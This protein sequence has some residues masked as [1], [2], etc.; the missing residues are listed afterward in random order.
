[1]LFVVQPGLNPSVG[2]A[3][4]GVPHHPPHCLLRAKTPYLPATASPSPVLL[5]AVGSCYHPAVSDEGAPTD[6][7]APNLEAGLPRPLALR[8]HGPTHNAA[9]GALEATVWGC[10]EKAGMNRGGGAG[11]SSEN[12]TE[13]GG[14]GDP[15]KDTGG[16]KG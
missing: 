11:E 2:T 8:G 15:R 10:G 5:E 4:L 12:R 9:G 3:S 16:G 1:M 14:G 7:S 6:V 13:K